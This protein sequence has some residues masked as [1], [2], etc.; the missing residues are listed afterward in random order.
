MTASSF[1]CQSIDPLKTS[2]AGIC[3]RPAGAK[4]AVST[5]VGIAPV[6]A[7]RRHLGKARAIFLRDR[8]RQ[9]GAAAE[10]GLFVAQLAPLDLEQQLLDR[11]ALERA[12][13]LPDQV[14]DVVLEQHDGHVSAERHVRPPQTESR[15][16]MT[17]IWSFSTS[18]CTVSRT[19]A[20]RHFQRSTGYDENH[21]R[22][23]V[24][25][26]ADEP[27]F[28]T[29][30]GIDTTCWQSGSCRASP[31]GSSPAPCVVTSVTL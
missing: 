21:D 7:R 28:G 15:T 20:T 4:Y 17:S 30:Y 2:R 6:F 18:A 24:S 8:D 29:S 12:Q 16:T 31:S 13:P 3:G 14:L 27:R 10:L 11:V 5:P 25:G 22:A 9:I 26:N 19:S 1:G 23:T